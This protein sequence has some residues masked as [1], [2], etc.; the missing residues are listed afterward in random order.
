MGVNAVQFHTPW[1]MLYKGLW[2]VYKQWWHKASA[3]KLW[4]QANPWHHHFLIIQRRHMIWWCSDWKIIFQM[5]L[6]DKRFKTNFKGF[7]CIICNKCR[8]HNLEKDL[9]DFF[10]SSRE[11]ISMENLDCSMIEIDTSILKRKDHNLAKAY[12][13]ALNNIRKCDNC[14]KY[15]HLKNVTHVDS[16]CKCII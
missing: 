3:W 8:L 12:E 13:V 7:M 4:V 16:T 9:Y 15:F 5:R 6:E 1:K 10:T 2:Q 11:F 14:L